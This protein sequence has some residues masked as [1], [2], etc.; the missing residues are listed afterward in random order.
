MSISLVILP[1]RAT[2]MLSGVSTN[3]VEYNLFVIENIDQ[4]VVKFI[5]NRHLIVDKRSI[6]IPVN[7]QASLE[8]YNYTE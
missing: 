7:V 1:M 3:S 4:H 6:N 8:Q 5:I 2:T